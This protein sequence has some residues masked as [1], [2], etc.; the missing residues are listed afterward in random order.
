M[1]YLD[2]SVLGALFF[3]ESTAPAVLARLESAGAGDAS[4]LAIARRIRAS[5]ATLDKRQAVAA[6][7][8]GV[9]AFPV[10]D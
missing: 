4:H 9:E 3:R 1:I 5:L 10:A 6:N 2:T 8:Y 7:H